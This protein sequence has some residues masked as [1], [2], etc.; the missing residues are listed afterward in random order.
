MRPKL[1][2]AG[3]THVGRIRSENQDAWATL[4]ARGEVAP[5]P[6]GDA[7]ACGVA[8]GVGSKPL[9]ATA[10]EQALRVVLGQLPRP[11]D[12]RSLA[13]V[14]AHANR[15]VRENLA[16]DGLTTLVLLARATGDRLLLAWVGDS[17]AMLWRLGAPAWTRQLTRP[18]LVGPNILSQALGQR[19]AVVPSIVALPL[20]RGPTVLL[21]SDGL[22]G[23]V[24]V[25][26]LGPV[27][28][29]ISELASLRSCTGFL[30]GLAK[31]LVEEAVR[32][33]GRDNVTV[34]AATVE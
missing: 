25:A 13:Q 27:T 7:W 20:Q 19:E 32:R 21:S 26:E 24:P 28:D 17:P 23:E 1:C 8:D 2:V 31:G 15:K 12:E 18:H 6:C 5:K 14:I 9:S 16:G 4:S 11:C 10:A 33:G 22:T 30:G 34:C 29:R 3:A